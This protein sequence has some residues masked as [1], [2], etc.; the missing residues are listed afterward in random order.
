M[1]TRHVSK[2]IYVFQRTFSCLLD[3]LKN[4]YQVPIASLSL[5]GAV[6]L[7]KPINVICMTRQIISSEH[8][9]CTFIIRFVCL[10]VPTYCILM[11]LNSQ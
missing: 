3:T 1:K 10:S 9:K 8:A 4:K 6:Y 7:H 2:V 5:H 11:K